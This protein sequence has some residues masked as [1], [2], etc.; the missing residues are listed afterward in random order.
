MTPE[1]APESVSTGSRHPRTAAERLFDLPRWTVKRNGIFADVIWLNDA[2]RVVQ[3]AEAAGVGESAD[4]RPGTAL[5]SG[6]PEPVGLDVERLRTAI[7]RTWNS[8]YHE[9]FA[10]PLA[11]EYA[12][13]AAATA[14]EGT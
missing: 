14:E 2:L 13:L 8:R 10:E 12:R 3:E 4:S 1:A 5:P 7:R 9:R 11:A 6:S